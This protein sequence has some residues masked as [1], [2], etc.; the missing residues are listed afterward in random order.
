[1]VVAK[2]T[3]HN[4]T[5]LN[6]W[7][8]KIHL[9]WSTTSQFF[10]FYPRE[11]PPTLVRAHSVRP[12]KT[13]RWSTL[14]IYSVAS[15]LLLL[16]LLE[17]MLATARQAATERWRTQ[18]KQ[19]TETATQWWWWGLYNV[20]PMLPFILTAS[21]TLFVH[22]ERG[23][24]GGWRTVDIVTGMAIKAHNDTRSTSSSFSQQ[25]C[26]LSSIERFHCYCI[27]WVL[28]IIC[29]VNGIEIEA[30]KE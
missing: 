20:C 12:S 14:N 6:I 3:S 10:P 19:T 21:H 1:M 16:L 15:S 29:C 30:R 25:C 28:H 8:F 18:C 23:E 4:K 7:P 24:R 5:V 2:N 22:P 13:I 9:K 11:S 17:R 26:L 27:L